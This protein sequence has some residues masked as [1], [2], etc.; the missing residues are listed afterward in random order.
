M[1]T[2]TFRILYVFVVLRHD[3]RQVVHFNVTTHPHAEWA[4]QQIINAFPW[5]E[6]PRF[7]IRD[8]DGIYGHEFTSRVDHMGIEEA[9]TAPRSGFAGHAEISYFIILVMALFDIGIDQIS[10]AAL[11]I[12]L[13]MLIDNAIVMSESIMV[14]MSEGRPAKAAAIA[15]AAG[16]PPSRDARAAASAAVSDPLAPVYLIEEKAIMSARIRIA[17]G[18]S[19][20]RRWR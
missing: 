6:A 18:A 1:P 16:R 14:Q 8:R 9:K 3:R 10:L 15:S 5:E 4:A 12:A 19:L 2:V 13:G 11:I 20:S 17:P 7:L